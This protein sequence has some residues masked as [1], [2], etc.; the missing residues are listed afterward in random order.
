MG[1]AKRRLEKGLPPRRKEARLRGLHHDDWKLGER[2]HTYVYRCLV[3]R[4]PR[5]CSAINLEVGLDDQGRM[6]L[7]RCSQGDRLC[8]DCQQKYLP[9]TEAAQAELDALCVTRWRELCALG[10]PCCDSGL[11][12]V[13]GWVE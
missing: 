10:C 5:G 13:A 2:L 4:D 8:P 11:I 7:V 9:M 6:M 3:C 1:E 12:F